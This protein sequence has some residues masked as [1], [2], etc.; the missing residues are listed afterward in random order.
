[1]KVFNIAKTEYI[2]YL[3]RYYIKKCNVFLKPTDALL[4][5]LKVRDV[6]KIYQ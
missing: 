1:M 5:N 3:A 2:G 4:I 6:I